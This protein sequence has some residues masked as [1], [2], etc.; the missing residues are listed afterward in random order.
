MSKG[1]ISHVITING[2]V[3][4]REETERAIFAAID[5]AAARGIHPRFARPNLA[6]L[7]NVTGVTFDGV[8]QS[9]AEARASEAEACA[10]RCDEPAPQTFAEMLTTAA[11]ARGMERVRDIARAVVPESG[12]DAYFLS[13]CEKVESALAGDELHPSA[14]TSLARA[15]GVSEQ[16]HFAWQS[17]N[18]T[19]PE[20]LYALI[21]ENPDRWHEVERLLATPRGRS[22]MRP[23]SPAPYSAKGRR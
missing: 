13:W 21:V 9:A 2:P 17:A 22:V 20:S 19:M 14:V 8:E 10:A 11:R 23:E 12:W 18:G 4:P 16:E 15:L 7:D 5:E 3:F 6:H 1:P